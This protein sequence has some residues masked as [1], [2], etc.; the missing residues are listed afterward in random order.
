MTS[1]D[2]RI[3]A[4]EAQVETMNRFLTET[5][6]WM[7]KAQASI[8]ALEKFAD[9]EVAPGDRLCPGGGTDGKRP[10]IYPPK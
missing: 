4:L 2:D 7:L 3:A 9:T 10:P 6:D 8:C 5:S 1:A